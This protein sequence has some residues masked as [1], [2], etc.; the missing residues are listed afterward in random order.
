MT[1]PRP[2][3]SAAR[4]Q[5]LRYTD[6]ER[7]PMLG[8]FPVG[9]RTVDE[10][11]A[12]MMGAGAWDVATARHTLV[13]ER[14]R[15][16]DALVADAAFEAAVRGLPFAATDRV[17]AV[18]DSISADRLGWFEL[19]AGARA[20]LGGGSPAFVNLAVSGSTSADAVERFD[21]LEEA[22]PTHV[23]LM[24]GTND[25]RGH[26]RRHRRTMASPGETARNLRVLADLVTG[27]LG[28]ELVLLT[29]PACDPGRAAEFFADLSLGW[30]SDDVAAVADAVRGLGRPY[31]DVHALTA[32]LAPGPTFDDD[33]VHLSPAGQLEVVRLV[34]TSLTRPS[35]ATDD[36]VPAG[37]TP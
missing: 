14:D 25:A 24:L 31:L 29:P 28:S 17:V 11:L 15:H 20:R 16:L 21:L 6:P 37:S 5:F 27:E 13:E 19:L 30:D 23:L 10:L 33:G 7:W 2:Q 26:G 22:A 4:A 34:V 32:G 8:R 35:R 12:A 1:L 3:T 18:G 9:D 36:A